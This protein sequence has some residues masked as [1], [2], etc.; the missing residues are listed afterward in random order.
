MAR[1]PAVKSAVQW[2]AMFPLISCL[3]CLSSCGDDEGAGPGLTASDYN[4]AGWSSYA[5]ED[6][7]NARANF[8]KALEL[9]AGFIEA[10][11]GLA[12]CEAHG[13][14]YPAALED[15]NEVMD[16]GEYV[17]DAFA[18]RSATA[19]AAS[20]DSLAIASAESTLARDPVYEFRRKKEYDW[21]DIRL[22]TAQA[23][24]ALAQYGGAQ[25]QVDI[26]DP[27]NGLDPADSESWVVNG[28]TYITYEAA[29]AMEIEWLWS[30]EGGGAL[31]STAGLLPGSR[32]R[33][34]R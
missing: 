10:R 3:V 6:Y 30:M 34:R 29:L 19:L 9:E 26:L 4:E 14:E 18:G 2:L 16:A 25:A 1:R 24:Y 21:R 22:I 12:W 31:A 8:G 28:Q 17:T 13:G 7:T 32:G 20:Q 33:A 23:H 5:V 11:L 15:F 27:D